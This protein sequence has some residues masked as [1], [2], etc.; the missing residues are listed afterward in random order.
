MKTGLT[1]LKRYRT[2]VILAVL[3]GI[4]SIAAPEKGLSAMTI[5]K[6]NLLEML[7]VL[8]PISIL[9]GLLDVWVP[10]E[11]M[12]KYMGKGSGIAGALLAFLLGSCAA[13]P[14]YIAFPIAGSL[15]KKKA[16]F[17]NVFVFVGAWSTTKVPMFLFEMTSMG[18]HFALMR[19][20]FSVIG[21][22]II[23]TLLDA[24]TDET[25]KA[26]IYQRAEHDLMPNASPQRKKPPSP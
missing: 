7:Y 5:T 25:E 21:I 8:L 24:T 19:L 13:G 6:H 4:L 14:L 20:G 18:W 17:F 12:M 15:L 26:A 9:L 23:A 1:V 22:V 16:S 3:I 10:K 11:T 2:A